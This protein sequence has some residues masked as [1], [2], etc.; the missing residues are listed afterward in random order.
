MVPWVI[1]KSSQLQHKQPVTW[2]IPSNIWMFGYWRI[3][4]SFWHNPWLYDV[5]FHCDSRWHII[6]HSDLTNI[7]VGPGG[8]HY[9]F[10][11]K[12]PSWFCEDCGLPNLVVSSLKPLCNNEAF[13][14]H[15]DL[16]GSRLSSSQH[17]FLHFYLKEISHLLAT[18]TTPFFIQRHHKWRLKSQYLPEAVPKVSKNMKIEHDIW[19]ICWWKMLGM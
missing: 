13:F 2:D 8:I 4:N 12:N 10:C 6:R 18:Q 7:T 3:I 17:V 1:T 9:N 16:W 11:T 15:S 19:L 14:N 5:V